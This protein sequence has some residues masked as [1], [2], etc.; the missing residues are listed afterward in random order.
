[1][2]YGPSIVKN[3]L[4]L[5]LDAADRNSYSGTGTV[6]KDISTNNNTAT[7]VAGPGYSF[8]N[9]GY[10]TFNGS[11][12]YALV[13]NSII[14]SVTNSSI[15]IWFYPTAAGQIISELGQSAINTSYHDSNIE[16]SSGGVISFSCW[17]GLSTNKVTSA[18]SFNSWYYLGFTY[19]DTL[20][21]AYI[22]GISVGTTTFTRSGPGSLYYGLCAADGTNM[23]T[24]AYGAGSMGNFKVYNRGLSALEVLQN[25]NA[26]KG[27]FN[28]Q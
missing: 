12:Q 11:T 19:S 20:L 15:F 28:L 26:L 6:W 16:I 4:V 2:R 22:N 25:Y 13:N 5:C 3:G 14:S 18:Q 1:M 21:T 17:P 10:F 7:L 24:Q 9:G 27:R 23:G 8:S